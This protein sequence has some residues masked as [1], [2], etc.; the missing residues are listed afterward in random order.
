M[1]HYLLLSILALTFM[2]SCQNEEL[3]EAPLQVG[4]KMEVSATLVDESQTRTQHSS[5]FKK[6][7]WSENDAISVFTIGEESCHDRYY[8]TKGVGTTSAKFQWDKSYNGTIIGGVEGEDSKED[9]FYVGVYP[10]MEGTSVKVSIDSYEINTMIPTNQKY[11]ENSFGQEA[12]VMV[13]VD[14]I[15]SKPNIAFKNVGTILIFPLNG[16]ATIQS[17]TLKSETCKIAGSAVVTVS[18][19]NN[20]IPSTDMS[21][22]ENEIT[23]SCG[24]GVQLKGEEY[25]NFCFVLA[26]G[27]YD[28]LVVKFT[29]TYGNYFEQK[30]ENPK[31]KEMKRSMSYNMPKM[32]FYPQ[33]TEEV[34]LWV[35]A[36]AGAS[37]SAE[38]IIPSVKD[39]D[40]E[41]W[42]KN[43]KDQAN[44]KALI[45]E[46]ITYIT[47][48]NYKAAYEVLG[49]IPGFVKDVKRFE[50]NG[51]FIQK[52]D[53][54]GVSY[55]VS[56]L[57]GIESI[58]NIQSLLDY[59]NEFE[60][61]YEA[62]GLKNELD[63][64]LGSI[65]NNF[66]TYIDDYVD[67]M[68]ESVYKE[69]ELEETPEKPELTEEEAFAAYKTKIKEQIETSIFSA[70]VQL[71]IIKAVQMVKPSAMK[72]E[73]Q[74]LEAY[75]DAVTRFKESLDG[76]T[77]IDTIKDNIKNLPK[78]NV[79]VSIDLG[80]WLGGVKTV[81][82]TEDPE[83]FLT[84]ADKDYSEW[85]NAMSEWEQAVKDQIAGNEQA[86]EKAKDLAKALV[87][88]E[89]EKIQ[90]AS[91]VESLET[92]VNE[93]G[94]TTGKVLNYLF[95]QESFMESVKTSLREIVTNIEEES[96]D[97]VDAGNVDKKQ[98]AINTAIQNALINARV[99]AVD[100]ILLEFNATNEANL[101][102]GP[103]AT[104]K[105]ILNWQKCVEVFAEL[106]ILDV[107]DALVEL[108]EVVD[109]M[110]TYDRGSILYDIEE[111]ADYQ[112][113]VD[114]WVLKFNEEL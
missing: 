40:V 64:K 107:Y 54:T 67:K 43:L 71:G 109:E 8:L 111:F 42:V 32:T 49:G 65:A 33:G 112:E 106:K 28:D 105:K 102:N 44:T 100:K 78:V 90:E 89:I 46:A 36:K 93:P 82:F 9:V 41:G 2:V 3:I 88:T 19:E 84:G 87:R 86:V 18:A 23:L 80:K 76:Y 97:K 73:K 83:N 27:T 61:V 37:M 103:W 47:L 57:E 99:D 96:K 21:N 14:L 45:E 63:K 17:V 51:S 110:I 113:H 50:A 95:A 48:K 15:N 114:W 85:E 30:I 108:S 69:P 29:D 25:T 34:D 12:F 66:D 94:S 60:K 24:E 1:K 62:S 10:F 72:E 81:E 101:N 58:N 20:F 52:V 6:V 26:P 22:G 91:L 74:Q 53:Y 55:L 56:M 68:W 38:R 92:A 31:S 5:D 75:I 98:Q 77:S 16:N 13:G 35:K 7:L 70:N 59:L 104:F 79:H 4:D 11:A 39:V